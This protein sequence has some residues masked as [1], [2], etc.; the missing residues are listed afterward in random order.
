[1]GNTQILSMSNHCKLLD[2][3]YFHFPHLSLFLSTMLHRISFLSLK[4]NSS[5]LHHLWTTLQ[6]V[7]YQPY[8]GACQLLDI[9]PT[10]AIPEWQEYH[11]GLGATSWCGTINGWWALFAWWA[12]SCL[13]FFCK[14]L[15]YPTP[16]FTAVFPVPPLPHFP[17]ISKIVL[18]MYN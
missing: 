17:H 10:L 13:V 7:Q 12:T 15:L 2:V 16:L 14:F 9:P 6:E 5:C 4:S 8:S 18:S 11:T 1:M 3:Q